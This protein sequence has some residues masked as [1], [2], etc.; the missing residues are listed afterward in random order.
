MEHS[1]L[2][3]LIEAKQCSVSYHILRGSLE[4]VPGYA[5]LAFLI[6]NATTTMGPRTE[7]VGSQP[8]GLKKQRLG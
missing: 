7:W 4:L 6:H 1:P 5:G 8:L 3:T 2:A